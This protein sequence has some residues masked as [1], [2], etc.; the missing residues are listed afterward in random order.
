MGAFA[1]LGFP[2]TEVEVFHTDRGGGFDN[3]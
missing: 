1:T 3:A 2:L